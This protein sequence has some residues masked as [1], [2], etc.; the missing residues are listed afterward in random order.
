MN[1]TVITSYDLSM[2]N[3]HPLLIKNCT[4]LL[5]Q[6]PSKT[7]I[8]YTYSVVAKSCVKEDG[9]VQVMFYKTGDDTGK[10]FVVKSDVMCEN[11]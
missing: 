1:I 11:I 2:D 8:E 5:V 6:V 9:H 4:H 3:I 10:S 7:K